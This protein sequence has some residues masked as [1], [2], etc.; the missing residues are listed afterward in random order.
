[1]LSRKEHGSIRKGRAAIGKHVFEVV[2]GAAAI[3]RVDFLSSGRKTMTMSL[4]LQ[5][6]TIVW[7]CEIQV[8]PVQS[9][10]TTV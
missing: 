4:G 10:I 7:K 2:L 5:G 8:R 3:L 6:V 9:L 1:M